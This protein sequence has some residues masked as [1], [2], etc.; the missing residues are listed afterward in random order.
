[1][2]MPILAGVLGLAQ[3][4]AFSWLGNLVRQRGAPLAAAI[5]LGL[6]VAWEAILLEVLSAFQAVGPGPVALGGLVPP[7]AALALAATRRGG[8]RAAPRRLLRALRWPAAAYGVPTLL[9]VPLAALL[10]V[11]AAAYGPSNWDSMTYHLARVAHWM[12]SRS[13]GTYP[14]NIVRQNYLGPGAEY[15][16]LLL[17]V[18]GGSDRLASLVQLVSW[19]IVVGAAPPLARLAGAPRRAAAWAGPLVAGTPMAVLQATSTQNDLVASA[20]AV[21]LV[22]A[23]APFLHRARRAR[24]ADL[25]VLGAL[26]A[27]AFLVKM[28]ALVAAAPFLVAAGWGLARAV[29]GWG[30]TRAASAL[31]ASLLACAAV[32]GPHLLRMADLRPTAKIVTAPF[33]YSPLGDW[34]DRGAGVLRAVARHLPLPDGLDVAVFRRPRPF[35]NWHEDYAPNPVQSVAVGA[36]LSA[37]VLRRR[38]LP[39]RSLPAAMGLLASWLLFQLTFRDNPWVTRLET[40]LFAL[41][42]LVFGALGRVAGTRAGGRSAK[43]GPH[44]EAGPERKAARWPGLAAAVMGLASLGMGAEAASH[45]RSRPVSGLAAPS[46]A[47]AGYYAEP[48]RRFVKQVDDAALEVA[49]VTGCRR[50]GLYIGE[51]D[52]D[53]PITWRAM[54]RGIEV[55]HVVGPDAWPCIVLS[56]RGPP[57]VAAGERPWIA[58]AGEVIWMR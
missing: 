7:L 54:Q 16:M 30:G 56:L 10:A 39:R 20:I 43:A 55:R 19:L 46:A 32:A 8:L 25:L 36:L 51:D 23:C 6:S 15:L 5:G 53:Y 44:A 52:Y 27:A 4:L 29:T 11:V 3:L 13:V 28:T 35:P 38:R 34:G 1:M 26:G 41:S 47:T 9:V 14:T 49:R 45:N 33:T 58:V 21:G 22:A 24:P 50:L 57:P 17:Q 48:A 12:E 42:P 18:V 40:P 31:A 37:A 2:D